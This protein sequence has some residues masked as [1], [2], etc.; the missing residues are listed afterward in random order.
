M[1][2]SGDQ[3]PYGTSEGV[4]EPEIDTIDEGDLT[5]DLGR[6]T[7]SA[8]MYTMISQIT[9]TVIKMA[10]MMVLARIIAPASFGLIA[11]VASIVGLTSLIG[12][13]GISV[14]IIQSKEISQKQLSSLFWVIVG[15]GGS[16]A[17][18]V[19]VASPA[20]A[21]FYSD[22]RVI[23]VAMMSAVSL[24]LRTPAT[25]HTAMLRRRLQLGRLAIVEVVAAIVSIAVAITLA[26][27][28]FGYWALLFQAMVFAG[29]TTL[30]ATLATGWFPDW[31]FS[32]GEI[33][34][35][36]KMGGNF[37]A[38]TIMNYIARNGDNVLIARVW[39]EASCAFYTKAYG[40]LLLPV[41]QISGP[42]GKVA[43]PALSRLQDEPERYNRFFYRG[44]TISFVLQIPIVIF[45]A[46][47]GREIVLAMLGPAWAAAVPIFVALTPALF[48]A[49]TGPATSWVFLS[50]GDTD[51]WFKMVIVNS[52]GTILAFF[53]GVKYG[54][55]GVAMGFSIS[56]VL[57]RIPN[58][59][60]CFQPTTL[61]LGKFLGL[62]VPPILC[63]V[64]SVLV[65]FAVI[66]WSGFANPWLV[67]TL[68]A[69]VFFLVY[70]VT[71]S[72]TSAGRIALETIRPHIP[73]RLRFVFGSAGT[74]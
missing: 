22:P 32:L 57:L 43:V 39:G 9:T 55:I 61:Q 67:V 17:V 42:M 62:M 73:K 12:D 66:H 11:K 18:A 74:P 7:M 34:E 36:L 5:K 59:L 49:A 37:T 31:H 20:I 60:Y 58:I 72:M 8:G 13:F 50:R 6:A 48:I 1:A 44:C 70:L 15:V 16:L 24:L 25:H 71:I 21:W 26:M 27:L 46:F 38:G 29:A 54:P 68:K 2:D 30:G 3:N 53:V 65:G 69:M 51:R 4:E 52:I 10:G 33:K 63:S 40:L 47:A 64:V 28:D 45:A 14:P 23:S 41:Q 56:A 19:V 35:K